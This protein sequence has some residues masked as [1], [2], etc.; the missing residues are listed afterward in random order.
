MG[1]CGGGIV[2]RFVVVVYGARVGRALVLLKKQFKAGFLLIR[3]NS[4]G[5]RL[6]F[7]YFL[8]VFCRGDRLNA[9]GWYFSP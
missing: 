6:F 8:A 1:G 3:R 4:A 5:F 7:G 9:G 2:A